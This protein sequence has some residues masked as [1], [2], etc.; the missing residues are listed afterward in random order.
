MAKNY[1]I[2]IPTLSLFLLGLIYLN[3]SSNFLFLCLSIYSFV[4][5]V[6]LY[7][8]IRNLHNLSYWSISLRVSI[9]LYWPSFC[10]SISLFPPLFPAVIGLLHRAPGSISIFAASSIRSVSLFIFHAFIIQLAAFSHIFYDVQPNLYLSICTAL[11]LSLPLSSPPL[12]LSFS[13]Q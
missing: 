13:L 10:I 12:C 11:S 1:F 4:F 2:C 3:L 7:S 6:S 5:E 9:H 8:F